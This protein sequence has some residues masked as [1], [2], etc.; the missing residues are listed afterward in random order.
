MKFKERKGDAVRAAF[1]RTGS[2]HGRKGDGAVTVT[3]QKRYLHKYTA[4]RYLKLK[5]K[6]VLIIILPLESLNQLRLLFQLVGF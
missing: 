4:Q 1:E 3:E 5:F 6:K 2:G